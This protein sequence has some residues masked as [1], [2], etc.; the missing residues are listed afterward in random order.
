MKRLTLVYDNGRVTVWQADEAS[1]GSD[2]R[3]VVLYRA[4]VIQVGEGV[5][6]SPV[7]RAAP[8]VLLPLGKVHAVFEEEW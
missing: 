6:A 4:K 2:A 7:T 8:R 5:P 1:F 3:N